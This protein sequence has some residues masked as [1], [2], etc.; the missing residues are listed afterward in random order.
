MIINEF[1]SLIIYFK[2]IFLGDVTFGIRANVLMLLGNW[3]VS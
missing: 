3:G 2:V 1:I